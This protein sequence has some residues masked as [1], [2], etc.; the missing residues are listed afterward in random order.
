MQLYKVEGARKASLLGAEKRKKLA[1]PPSPMGALVHLWPRPLAH[2][3]P[4]GPQDEIRVPAPSKAQDHVHLSSGTTVCKT[5][6]KHLRV[7]SQNQLR[8]VALGLKSILAVQEGSGNFVLPN[9]RASPAVSGP[10][11]PAF[12]R[13]SPLPPSSG[14]QLPVRSAGCPQSRLHPGSSGELSGWSFST[15]NTAGNGSGRR[16][17]GQCWGGWLGMPAGWSPPPG[18]EH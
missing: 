14:V 2:K 18:E 17:T 4:G 3:G 10:A 12:T 5:T 16:P 11:G 13:V 7:G 1:E 8:L 9:T 15:R 6:G